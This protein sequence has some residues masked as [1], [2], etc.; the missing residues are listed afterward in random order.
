MPADE[1]ISTANSLRHEA[2]RL[3]SGLPPLL[4][5]AERIAASVLPGTHGRRRIG[6]GETFWQFRRYQFGDPAR[7]IDWR[8]SARSDRIYIRQQEWEAAQSVW[9]WRDTSPS[10]RFQSTFAQEQKR[11]RADVLTLALASLL[12]RGGE[13]V[14]LLGVDEMP[15]GGRTA[16]ETT[17]MK[18]GFPDT[19]E[20]SL[21]PLLRIR[22][23]SHL[24]MIGDFLSPLVEIDE[25]IRAYVARGVHGHLLQILDP[26]EEDLPFSGHVRFEGLEGEGEQTFGRVEAIASDYHRR[27]TARREALANMCRQVG[28]S[29]SLHRTDHSAQAALLSIYTALTGGV[30]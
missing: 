2:E 24:V 23:H 19:S 17:A 9:L 14:G 13:H 7:S 28:W 15:R 29:H 5:R 11:D 6:P 30:G 26:V 21:P 25:L 27:M 4:V 10:M 12:I 3:A 8:R 18:L 20:L 22:R 1:N 16:I